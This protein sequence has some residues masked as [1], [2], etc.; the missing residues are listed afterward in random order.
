MQNI[1]SE[2][3][4]AAHSGTCP[5][6]P[7]E[8]LPAHDTACPR[9][10]PAPTP[11]PTQQSTETLAYQDDQPQKRVDLEEFTGLTDS[12]MTGNEGNSNNEQTKPLDNCNDNLQPAELTPD[13]NLFG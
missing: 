2:T 10:Q 12:D 11:T 3:V 1:W 5:H 8:P 13:S 6:T 7:A 4:V 9:R